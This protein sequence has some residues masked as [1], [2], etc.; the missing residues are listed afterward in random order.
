V[1]RFVAK[2]YAASAA[3]LRKAVAHTEQRLGAKHPLTAVSRSSLGAALVE[4]SRQA[5]AIPLLEAALA[6]QAANSGED[7]EVV[8][9][10]RAALARAQL[11]TGQPA[12][13]IEVGMPALA[14]FAT[15]RDP[16]ARGEVRFVLARALVAVGRDGVRAKDLATQ[17][18]AD[19]ALVPDP[20]K[21]AAV[22]RL[23]A[24]LAGPARR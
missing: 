3:W 6:V 17:A 8:A 24:K 4:Q 10:T 18:R 7:A 15:S 2:Q 19:Y 11:E 9:S 13:A 14:F 21:L 23:L 1:N 22:D 16:S 5:E 12:R 20:D